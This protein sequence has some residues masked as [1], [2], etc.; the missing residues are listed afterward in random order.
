[1][2]FQNIKI[3]ECNREQ[4]A[5]KNNNSDNNAIFTNR[6][7]EVI[8]LNPGDEISL[9]SAFINK[10]GTANLNS[11]EF[12]GKSLGVTGKFRQSSTATENPLTYSPNNKY[13]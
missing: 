8:E 2:S 12:K 10:R 11:I 3:L 13:K 4:S 5:E 9:Q 7:G 1:M 6:M